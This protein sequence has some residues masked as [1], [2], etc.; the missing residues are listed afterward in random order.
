MKSLNATHLCVALQ[1]YNKFQSRAPSL[2]AMLFAQMISP[3][4]DF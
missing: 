3:N 1:R 4:I 2:T